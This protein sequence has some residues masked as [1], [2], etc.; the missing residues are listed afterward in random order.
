MAGGW[1]KGA[2]G[3][4]GG[5][6]GD[7]GARGG[8]RVRAGGAP[9]A[10]SV[11]VVFP[12]KQFWQSLA[13]SWSWSNFPA[14]Q[15]VHVSSSA[16]SRPGAYCVHSEIVVCMEVSESLGRDSA[17]T[18]WPGRQT[19]QDVFSSLASSMEFAAHRVA[20]QDALAGWSECLPGPHR[21]HESV[22]DG[23]C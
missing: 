10:L 5:A 2:G 11:L 9:G 19:T 6:G 22:L 23:A 16:T 14:G 21:T 7:G 20:V 17:V 4:G 18:N 3:Y 12:D 13:G 15:I 8:V 1:G